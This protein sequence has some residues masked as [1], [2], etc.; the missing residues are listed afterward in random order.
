M[1]VVKVGVVGVGAWGKNIVRVFKDLEREDL[2]RVVGV[3]D[4]DLNKA[5]E[6]AKTY[7][8]NYFVRTV[9]ELAELGVEA[10]AVSV[11]I[12]ELFYVAKEALSLGLHV[13]I[14]KPVSTKSEEVAELIKIA[15]SSSLVVQPGFIVRYDPGIKTLK[16]VLENKIKYL[17]F[18][19]LSARPPHRRKYS[20]VLDLMIHDI[21]LVLNLVNPRKIELMSAVGLKKEEGIPQEVHATLLLDDVVAYLVT[22]GTLP[23]KVRSAEVVTGSAYY[24]VSFTDSTI[25]VKSVEGGHVQKVEGE[26]PLKAELRDFV[27]SVMGHKSSEAPTLQDALKAL[28]IAELIEQRLLLT[29]SLDRL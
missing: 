11:P 4:T 20:V 9:R 16:K 1:S 26:E 21:D 13:F 25:L 27:M 7:K 23:V 12:N 19:R 15:E 8:I 28:K 6:V 22:D 24:E 18:K 10:V 14:E 2:V 17:I 5:L 3:A 29:G